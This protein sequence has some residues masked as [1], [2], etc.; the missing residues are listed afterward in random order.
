VSKKKAP[1]RG[2]RKSIVEEYKAKARG[3][4]NS[5]VT[6]S[7]SD[8]SSD[9][10]KKQKSSPKKT[11][12]KVKTSRK[13]K[14]KKVFPDYK[15][16]LSMTIGNQT[17]EAGDIAWYVLEGG[18]HSRRPHSGDIKECYPT[19]ATEPCVCVLDHQMGNY[20]T[21]RARLVGWNKAEA[22]K[23]WAEFVEDNPAKYGTPDQS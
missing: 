16:V 9:G 2:T 14:V 18:A 22:K 11:T 5:E 7:S 6:S 3:R 20:R 8:E 13:K 21:V 19:D 23:K 17:Y 1:A 15:P 12:N 4:V 10:A